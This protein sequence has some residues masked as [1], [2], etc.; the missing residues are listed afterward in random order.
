MFKTPF[1]HFFKKNSLAARQLVYILL[2]SSLITLLSASIQIFMEYKTDVL[3][4]KEQIQLVKKSHL[5]SLTH[6]LWHIDR[7]QIQLQLNDALNLRD[8]IYLEIKENGQMLYSAGSVSRTD[9]NLSADFKISYKHAGTDYQIGTL[10]VVA[11]L[12]RTHTKLWGRIVYILISQSVKT[13]LVSFFILFIIHRLVTRHLVSIAGQIK[14]FNMKTGHQDIRLDRRINYDSTGDELDFLVSSFNEMQHQLFVDIKQQKQTEKAL[15]M[16]HKRFITILNSIDATVYVADMDTYEILFMNQNMIDVFG[17]D[18]TGKI[19]WQVFRN[20]TGTCRKCPNDQLVDSDKNPKGLHIWQS[21][22]PVTQKWYLN[23]DRAIE[24]IDGRI[25]KIQIATDITDLKNMEK[26][27]VQARKYESIS[28][29]T[30]GIAHD[31]NNILSI[32]MGNTELALEDTPETNPTR[33]NLTEIQTAS[34]RAKQIVRQLLNSSRTSRQNQIPQ[35][36][37]PLVKACVNQFRTS[38]PPHT[39]LIEDICETC[40]LVPINADQIQQLIINLCTNAIQAMPKKGGILEIHLKDRDRDQAPP[41]EAVDLGPGAYV[42]LVVKDNGSGIA[43]DILEKIFDPYFTTQETGQ[44]SGMGLAVVHGIIQNHDG[45]FFIDSE[46][47]KG[48]A[49]SVFLPAADEKT[50]TGA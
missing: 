38:V 8:I 45:S 1:S 23:Y 16:S 35:N 48:T 20:G 29:L 44:G 24:W 36:L 33:K 13:F 39:Q 3:L 43:P 17:Q 49:F 5:K 31:F 15:K 28:L 32:I 27:L 42:E 37:S 2:F 7:A 21:K 47:G 50:D 6:S 22:N 41:G 34:I 14:H 25:V 9:S 18:F 10:A 11:S 19:C 12:A 40:R 46:P 26:K 30:G 4:V